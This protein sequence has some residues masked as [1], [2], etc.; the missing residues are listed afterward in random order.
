MSRM[1]YSLSSARTLLLLRRPP[2]RLLPQRL[3]RLRPRPP[4]RKRYV[5]FRFLYVTFLNSYPILYRRRRRRRRNRS[6]LR[7]AVGCLL[8]WATFSSPRP[9][10][11]RL[12]PRL[13]RTLPSLPS[14][15]P[16]PPSRTL[17]PRPLLLSQ[18]RH[19]RRQK[20]PRRR[21]RL[22]LLSLL[23]PHKAG[24]FHVVLNVMTVTMPSRR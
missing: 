4:R 10:Q 22:R 24:S 12:H 17:R 1:L 21:H 13:R 6:L 8:A 14:R 15:S 16:S 9:R 20:N 2:L 19:P 7:S 5:Y 23:L 18:R 11:S 3:P